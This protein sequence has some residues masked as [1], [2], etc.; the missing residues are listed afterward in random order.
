MGSMGKVRTQIERMHVV[1]TLYGFTVSRK[2]P[3]SRL[4]LQTIGLARFCPL[5]HLKKSSSTE[6]SLGLGLIGL[7]VSNFKSLHNMKRIL[8]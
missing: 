3:C 8:K 7:M 4:K 6:R 2:K 5:H 1:N